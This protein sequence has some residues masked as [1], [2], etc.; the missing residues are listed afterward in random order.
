MGK[1]VHSKIR[2]ELKSD[3]TINLLKKQARLN[4]WRNRCY[5]NLGVPNDSLKKMSTYQ[6]FSRTLRAS[7][8]LSLSIII[9]PA[10]AQTSAN[11]TAAAA[12]PARS[13]QATD[14]SNPDT[15]ETTSSPR[16]RGRIL[17]KRNPIASEYQIFGEL[18]SSPGADTD[19]EGVDFRAFFPSQSLFV[20]SSNSLSAQTTVNYNGLSGLAKAGGGASFLQLLGTDRKWLISGQFRSAASDRQVESYES[21]WRQSLEVDSFGESAVYF[22]DRPRYSLDYIL[23]RN[24]TYGLQVGHSFGN[25][26]SIF[27]KNSYQDYYD[28]FYR[29]RLELQIGSGEFAPNSPF[30]L[31]GQN[32]VS[33]SFTDA[34]TRR[35]FGDTRNQ[36]ERQHHTIGGTVTLAEWNFDFAV[37]QH[38]WD[39]TTKWYNW[40]FRDFGLDYTYQINDANLPTFTVD[41]G[42]D[43][44]DQSQAR[45]TD[46][47]IHDS[48]TKDT[49]LAW[50]IDA[51]GKATFNGID[52]WIQTG[53]LHREKARQSSE[54]RDVFFSNPADLFF[55][56]EVENEVGPGKIIDAQFE[57]QPGLDTAKALALF[58]TDPEKFSFSG[59]RSLVES[60]PRSYDAFEE[61]V[62]AYTLGTTQLGDWTVELGAR[63]ESTKTKSRGTVVIPTA[64]NDPGEGVFIREVAVPG[65]D[66]IEVI[67]EIYADNSYTNTLP[68]IESR[69][70]INE[71]AS[72]KTSWY[73]VLMRP[74]YFDIVNYRRISVPTRNISEGNPGLSPTSIDKFRV[75]YS[76]E[77]P[78]FG[79]LSV[80]LYQIS[81]ENFFYG[82][83]STEYVTEDGQPVEYAVSR[84]QNGENGEIRGFELQWVKAYSELP[85]LDHGSSR[86]AYTYS[87]SSATVG[88]RPN[89]SLTV[90]ERSEHLLKAS[91]K[92]ETG[93]WTLGVDLTYQSEALDDVGDIPERDEYREPVVALSVNSQYDFSHRTTLSLN[94]FN[95]TNNPERSYEADPIRKRRNQ[96]S[97]WY[98]VA[99]LKR[100]F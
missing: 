66:E 14:S 37:Y 21:V 83:V 54:I 87:D 9:V 23:T 68:S 58:S 56:S 82:A 6:T 95:L 4:A 22:L 44:R 26:Q 99:E 69:Y 15:D 24:N 25:G 17:Q 32:L 50:R 7:A 13:P 28:N 98:A 76:Y 63:L 20:N 30:D 27:Y 52:L 70:R 73:Q 19:G 10:F 53:M 89:E 75:A 2:F 61:V 62:S 92:G 11:G 40:N 42:E 91:L 34:R 93:N 80:E 43:I 71:N 49:D 78:S 74:Q 55:L 67:K 36:R 60:A 65:G 1:Y 90:P 16:E 48:A 33:A 79:Q 72:L 57:H 46:L 94:V 59:Y 81:I 29:S 5:S 97:S 41:S 45:F 31:N 51:E 8:G 18:G 64:L 84:V 88:T 47:R 86:L 35:Y 96:Y 77:S 100:T 3:S 12:T 39:L 85:L 38:A